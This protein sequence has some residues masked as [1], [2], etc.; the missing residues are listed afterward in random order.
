MEQIIKKQS[1]KEILNDYKEFKKL[2][3]DLKKYNYSFY[4][5]L[6]QVFRDD[7]K[8]LSK[9]CFVNKNQKAVF[10][11]KLTLDQELYE[12][13]R[14]NLEKIKEYHE[15]YD[16]DYAE[17][18]IIDQNSINKNKQFKRYLLKK[19]L[20]HLKPKTLIPLKYSY[21][22]TKAFNNYFECYFDDYF[23]HGSYLD[24]IPE[25][26]Q[27]TIGSQ[28]LSS[29]FRE[30]IETENKIYDENN[31]CKLDVNI[32]YGK[33][34]ELKIIIGNAYKNPFDTIQ[35]IFH[36]FCKAIQ[37][38]N[39]EKTNIELY[40]NIYRKRYISTEEYNNISKDCYLNCRYIS[41]TQAEL[42]SYFVLF[43]KSLITNN[44]AV[45]DD[46]IKQTKNAIFDPNLTVPLAGRFGYPI[47]EEYLNDRTKLNELKKFI[48]IN[49][50]VDYNG[51]YNFVMELTLNKQ[52]EYLEEL[53]EI[54]NIDGDIFNGCAKKDVIDNFI[55]KCSD[56]KFVNDY[57]HFL[58]KQEEYNKNK[59]KRQLIE[60]EFSNLL[61]YAKFFEQYKNSI[62]K[63]SMDN[64]IKNLDN[65]LKEFDL[66]D[67]KVI[68]K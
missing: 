63:K 68:Y 25:S 29:W 20:K 32:F 58:N 7:I 22:G 45:I 53:L 49:G 15:T 31:D 10:I 46:T 65:T 51:I 52:K 40:Q 13:A 42:F 44:E 14:K 56:T 26:I 18:I 66:F 27:T 24:K 5:D 57:L 50:R 9:L 39:I 35:S 11:N 61:I 3:Y 62:I 8:E 43:I 6:I 17:N 59:S 41:E 21:S 1:K 54:D 12:D 30:Y 28:Y 23:E 37:S 64:I 36:Q 48:T 33:G 2:N 16:K 19:S 67:E 60:E 47:I 55:E 34:I 38:E 4:S